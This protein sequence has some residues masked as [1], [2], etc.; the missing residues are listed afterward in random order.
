MNICA[1]IVVYT[2][3]RLDISLL[4]CGPVVVMHDA[5]HGVSAVKGCSCLVEYI[6]QLTKGSDKLGAIC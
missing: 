6:D 4:T 1:Y 3:P 5:A 2:A